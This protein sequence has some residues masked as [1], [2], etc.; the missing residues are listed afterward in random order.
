MSITLKCLIKKIRVIN[1]NMCNPRPKQLF[2]D[3]VRLN[4]KS[5]N[6]L[7]VKDDHKCKPQLIE[8]KEKQLATWAHAKW[9][10]AR[11]NFPLTNLQTV[12]HTIYP[13]R[14]K[15]IRYIFLIIHSQLIKQ[16]ARMSKKRNTI[17]ELPHFVT[18]LFLF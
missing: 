7:I 10:L 5:S 8:R 12:I 4:N 14:M 9:D 3:D 6:L 18:V 15:P 13:I 1:N 11:A 16:S 17:R 2:S